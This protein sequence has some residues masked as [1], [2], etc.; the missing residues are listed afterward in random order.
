MEGDKTLSAAFNPR[1][2]S[3]AVLSR[4]RNG[5]MPVNDIAVHSTSDGE[6]IRRIDGIRAPQQRVLFAPGGEELI[7]ANFW[8]LGSRAE[9]W[10]AVVVRL[11]RRELRSR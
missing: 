6:L 8:P 5:G 3:V 1:G 7:L 11:S 9:D 2:D 4:R 10:F